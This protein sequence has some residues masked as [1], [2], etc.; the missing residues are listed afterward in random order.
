MKVD[1]K[2]IYAEYKT[3]VLDA[4]DEMIN[5]YPIIQGTIKALWIKRMPRGN[6]NGF[7]SSTLLYG[8][9]LQYEI[10][11]NPQAF[12]KP[13]I[14][15]KFITARGSAYY[16]TVKNIIY[17]EVGHSLQHFLPCERYGL[18]L[19]R[20]NYFNYRKYRDVLESA[21]TSECYEK[22]LDKF[23]LQF[24]W[25]KNEFAAYFGTYAVENPME[26]LPECFSNYYYLKNKYPDFAR[27]E[28]EAYRFAKMVIEDYR[29]YIPKN[30]LNAE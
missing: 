28:Q 8:R 16:Y 22:Y 21:K 1:L 5:E 27:G 13:N 3:D 14:F 7:A 4:I 24:G 10:K 2:K 18:E 29:K 30:E 19:C 6:R 25:S 15:E 9:K 11:L 20:Y 17:H 12:E 26:V 23:L